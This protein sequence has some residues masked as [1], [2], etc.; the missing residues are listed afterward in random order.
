MFSIYKKK[1][2]KWVQLV[3][4]GNEDNKCCD[5]CKNEGMSFREE[6][7]NLTRLF[8]DFLFLKC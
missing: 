7:L 4:T 6:S 5:V 1:R 2:C 3:N 8:I